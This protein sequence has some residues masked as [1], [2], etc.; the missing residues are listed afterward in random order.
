[1][2]GSSSRSAVRSRSRSSSRAL[3]AA[4]CLSVLKIERQPLALMDYPNVARVLDAGT[5]ERGRPYFVMEY[6]DGVPITQYCDRKA[7]NT[8]IRLQ[9]V[10]SGLQ[11]AAARAQKGHQPP[12]REAFQR[13]RDGGGREAGPQGHRFW[14]RPGDGPSLGGM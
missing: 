14:Q 3:T 1:L 9:F 4:K 6:V 12:R 11:C 10:C 13:P 2:P 5:S 7:L 8:R